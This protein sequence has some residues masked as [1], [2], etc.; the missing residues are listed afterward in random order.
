MRRWHFTEGNKSEEKNAKASKSVIKSSCNCG[1]R[2]WTNYKT[3]VSSTDV[4][5]TDWKAGKDTL[6]KL[7]D[8]T[9]AGMQAAAGGSSPIEHHPFSI[10]VHTPEHIVPS[11][12]QIISPCTQLEEQS[13]REYGGEPSHGFSSAGTGSSLL[14]L[15]GLGCF[16]PSPQPQ[17]PQGREWAVSSTVTS[18]P[19]AGPAL[20]FWRSPGFPNRAR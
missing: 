13:S 20:S 9:W 8:V 11:S 1:V 3:W 19:R 14:C 5:A 6:A 10:S 2:Y 16:V 4:T 7:K 18:A 15:T 12:L 17:G